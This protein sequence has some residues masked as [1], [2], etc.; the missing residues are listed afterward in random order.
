[1]LHA[2]DLTRLAPLWRDYILR[3]HASKKWRGYRGPLDTN[4]CK[5]M[6]G[7]VFAA[8]QLGIRHTLA[9]LQQRDVDGYQLEDSKVPSI[10]I[11]RIWFPWTYEAGKKWMARDYIPSYR[12]RGYEV[13]CKCNNSHLLDIP[14]PLPDGTDFVSRV[15]ATYLHNAME[16]YPKL[17]PLLRQ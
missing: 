3:I 4:W 6:Y 15:T 8:A 10:H 11:G 16:T 1:M 17:V 12:K 7:Y 5:E 13:W 2:D 14:W 9:K